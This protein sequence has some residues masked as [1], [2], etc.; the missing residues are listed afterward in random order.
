MAIFSYR[1]TTPQGAILEGVI[2]AVDEKTAVERLKNTGVIPLTVFRAGK[3][4]RISLKS[5]KSDILTFTTELSALLG[6]GLPLDRSLNILSEISESKES[7]DIVQSILKSIREGSSFSEALQ[8]HPKV[9]PRI[10]VNMVKAGEAGGVLNV[11]LD[12]LN[13]F[14]ESSKELKDLVFSAMI[15]PAILVLTGSASII[16]LLTFVLPKFTSIFADLGKTLPLP[17]QILLTVSDAL[18]TYWW[19]ALSSI[20]AAWLLFKNFVRSSEGRYKWDAIKLKLMSDVIRKLETARF[21]RTLGTLLK[22]GV[23]LLQA[24]TN[25]KD[26]ISNQVIATSINKVTKGAKEGKGIAAPLTNAH[27]L[28]PL[29]LSMIKVGEET[30]QLDDMLLKVATTYEKSLKTA[31]KRFVSFLEPAMILIMALVIGFIVIS[32]LMAIFSIT[33]LPS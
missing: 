28:P 19:V 4:K 16:I 2:D 33:E 20:I 5:A 9:F 15:Y 26:V 3:K 22:S 7:K 12:K 27:V 31:I 17:T 18:Q 25:A 11:V 23:P 8:Q 13:E 21:C 6:A 30:G 14:L 10:Y 1:A 32:M 24:L 29:A